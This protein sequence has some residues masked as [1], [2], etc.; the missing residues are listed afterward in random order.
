VD[1]NGRRVLASGCQDGAV[2]VH[3][4]DDGGRMVPEWREHENL[5]NALAVASGSWEGGGEA[6]GRAVAASCSFDGTVRLWDIGGGAGSG[7][8]VAVLHSDKGKYLSSVSIT[9]DARR[10]LFESWARF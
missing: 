10:S 7:G 6:S 9:P 2:R 5:V 1:V 4:L 3:D 8:C